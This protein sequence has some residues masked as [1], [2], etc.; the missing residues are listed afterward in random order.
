MTPLSAWTRWVLASTIGWAATGVLASLS[1]DLNSSLG[2]ALVAIGQWSV[3]RRWLHGGGMW[4]LVTYI[5][6]FAGSLLGAGL[7]GVLGFTANTGRIG[8]GWNMILW[9]VQGAVIGAVQAYVVRKQFDGLSW[10]VLANALGFALGAP[11]TQLIRGGAL[12]F[13]GRM[14]SMTLFGLVSSAVSGLAFVTLFA[15]HFT[16]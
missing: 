5:A 13:E 11:M 4:V 6:G 14:L 3:I 7:I 16:D 10:W 1:N 2:L 15:E 8:A 12:G 9:A